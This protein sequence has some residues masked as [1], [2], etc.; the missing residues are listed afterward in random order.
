M[1]ALYKAAGLSLEDDLRSLHQAPRISADQGAFEYLARFITFNGDLEKPVMSIHT[2]GDGLVP[3]E[4]EQTYRQVVEEEG[5]ARLLRQA[6]VHRA[7]HCTF[8]E[9]ETLAALG[10]LIRR[11]DTG[12]WDDGAEP[13]KL[14]DSAAALG[15]AFNPAPPAYVDYTPAPYPRPYTAEGSGD[16]DSERASSEE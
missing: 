15:A 8:T 14:N 1:V 4:S 16:G 9:G 10:A 13:D 3:V 12:R 5:E 6:F 7:G 2:T 11:L